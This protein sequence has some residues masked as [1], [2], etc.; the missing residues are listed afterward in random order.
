MTI[1][2][3]EKNDIPTL[4]G[5]I[6][7]EPRKT[8]DKAIIG[9]DTET[10][11]VVYHHDL[12]VDTLTTEYMD[13]EDT[14]LE[15]AYMDAYDWVS[16]NTLRAIPYMPTPKPLVMFWNEDQTELVLWDTE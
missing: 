10:N 4:D 12:L 6:Y 1:E 3:Y 7:L 5:S 13:N 2:F 15:E 16:Y 9:H 11:G 14:T 8:F